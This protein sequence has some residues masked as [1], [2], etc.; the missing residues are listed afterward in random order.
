M[1]TIWKAI[2]TKL[3]TKQALKEKNLICAKS[4]YILKPLVNIV[5]TGIEAF[6]IME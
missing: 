3:L 2:S 1:R 5:P 4:T 6:V